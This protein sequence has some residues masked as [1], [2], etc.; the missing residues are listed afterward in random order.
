MK[1]GDHVSE[2][3]LKQSVAGLNLV[4]G[5]LGDQLGTGV[6]LLV[7]L[8]QFGCM[9]CRETMADLR[10]LAER[11]T[12]FPDVLFFFEGTPT[13][14]RAFLRRY[15]PG[16]RAVA[17][18]NASFYDAFGVGRGG[19]LKMFGRGVWPGRAQAR[20]KG[21]ANGERTGDIWRM[22][23]V[24]MTHGNRIVW[25]HEYRHAADHPDYG[26]IGS[27]ASRE[28]ATSEGVSA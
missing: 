26:V 10:E 21:H 24:F 7:F 20:E 18:P 16:V 28:F 9:F 19:L 1:T 27:I 22:P 13:A 23:G 3:T 17:D 15:W 12:R 11:N 25:A 6:N 4:P 5:T 8:R 2:T 14:G